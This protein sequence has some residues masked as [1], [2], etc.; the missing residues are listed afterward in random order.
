MQK[1]QQIIELIIQSPISDT[2]KV[3][4]ITGVNQARNDKE[5]D[6]KILEVAAF[7]DHKAD[8]FDETAGIYGKYQH[9]FEEM[10]KDVQK[11]KEKYTS[12]K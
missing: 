2:E 11:I 10:G 8:E 9:L 5:L 7:L 1:L 12:Q 6:N 3:G 4:L